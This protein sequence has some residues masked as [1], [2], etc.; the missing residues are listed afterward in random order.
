MRKDEVMNLYP[1]TKKVEKYFNWK[2]KVKLIQGLKKTI[3]S[4]A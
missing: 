2:P 4:Y 1:L 3:K